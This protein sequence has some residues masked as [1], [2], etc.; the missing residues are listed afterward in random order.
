[1]DAKFPDRETRTI[2][3]LYF[4]TTTTKHDDIYRLC[5]DTDDALIDDNDIR[6][7]TLNLSDH[8]ANDEPD[9]METETKRDSMNASLSVFDLLSHLV[10]YLLGSPINL[11]SIVVCL[12]RQ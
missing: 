3:N 5:P 11:A 2:F 8:V 4:D 12:S 9:D 7:S 1:M 6:Q 10:R